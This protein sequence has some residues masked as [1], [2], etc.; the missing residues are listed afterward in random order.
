[1]P[2]GSFF[3]FKQIM[4][5][6]NSCENTEQAPITPPA[7][8]YDCDSYIREEDGRPENI[9]FYV[10]YGKNNHV[11]VETHY[12]VE[13]GTRRRRNEDDILAD[14]GDLIRQMSNNYYRSLVLTKRPLFY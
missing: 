13:N 5:N 6:S 14:V 3:F 8:S 2:P 10:K 9:T 12:V 4:G 11:K 7:N 1:M